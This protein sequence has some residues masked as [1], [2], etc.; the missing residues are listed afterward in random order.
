MIRLFKD[1]F[2]DVLDELSSSNHNIFE[3]KTKINKTEDGYKVFV[4]V[5]GLTKDDLKIALKEGIL[6]I[7]YDN[8]SRSDTNH[9]VTKFDKSYTIPDNVNEKEIV[10]KVENGLL[11]IT[12]PI[13]KKKPVE[14]FI[15]LN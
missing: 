14:R 8:E 7:S 12:L 3:P 11:E 13:G 1:P 10:G 15:S 6:K 4:S 9:F 2:F 5:P